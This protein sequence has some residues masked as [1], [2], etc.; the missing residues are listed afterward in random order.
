MKNKLN[1]SIVIVFTAFVAAL[2]LLW[3]VTPDRTF[4]DRENRSL[5][6]APDFSVRS[7][8]SGKLMSGFEKY[9]SDQFGARDSWITLNAA[10]EVSLAKMENSGVYLASDGML[11]ERFHEPDS[12]LL[13][14]NIN[15][16]RTIALRLHER[17]VPLYFTLVPGAVS[18]L[19][20]RLPRNAPNGDQNAVIELA[21]SAL[22]DVAAIVDTRSALLAHR[23][24]PIYFR[25]DHH[26]T[27]LGA[28]YGYRALMSAMS[29][30]ALPLGE[31][32]LLSPNFYGTAYSSSGATWVKPDALY[33]YV[34]DPG[35]TALD[36]NS[37][38]PVETTLYHPVMLGKKDKYTY[39]LGGNSPL[40]VFRTSGD[41][42]KLLIIRDSYM[43]IELP[44]L[45]AHFSEIHLID[46]RYFNRQTVLSYAQEIGADAVLVSY[47]VK[48]FAEDSQIKL[49]GLG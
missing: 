7:L 27:A 29:L 20:D 10:V 25:T 16:V 22:S 17:G 31:S 5:A 9:V 2:T 26:W 24:E 8:T 11:V 12:A 35:V 34:R 13:D 33:A 21:S 32:E 30:D 15:A 39:F 6:L 45:L 28:Y 43:D 4:S 23:D 40:R 18:V 49:L 48:N 38:K 44:F 1:L 46:L 19:S 3:I 37:G 14:S 41:G 36:Y 42:S 47:S